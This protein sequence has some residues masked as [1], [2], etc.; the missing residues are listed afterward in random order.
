[1]LALALVAAGP[2]AP[3][4]APPAVSAP[5]IAPPSPS[6]PP[7]GSSVALVA[8]PA[9][10]P[11]DTAGTVVVSRGSIPSLA[12]RTVVVDPGHGPR[13]SG[14]ADHG[15]DEA[16]NVL[17]IGLALRDLLERAGARVVL[18]RQTMSF[19]VLPED[20]SAGQLRARTAIANRGT[21]DAFVS[22]HN[23]WHDDDEAARG[24]M[25]FHAPRAGSETLARTVQTG[26]FE[27]AGGRDRGIAPGGYHVLVNTNA[28]A[29]LVEMGFLSNEEDAALAKDEA[30]RTRAAAGIFRGLLGFL[31]RVPR[32]PP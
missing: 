16:A 29:V 21:A 17:A 14:A 28:P 24:S 32:P 5:P 26:L 1:M 18:T 19:P 25:T 4:C 2:V 31:G 12:G 13:G 7:N 30:F 23:N 22:L 10:P 6:P 9:R 11:A 3:A 8:P 20:P 15:S 27:A